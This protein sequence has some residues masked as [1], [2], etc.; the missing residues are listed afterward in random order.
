MT[1]FIL[2]DPIT[3]LTPRVNIHSSVLSFPRRT[4][5]YLMARGIA[6]HTNYQLFASFVSR[7]WSFVLQLIIEKNP[8]TKTTTNKQKTTHTHTHTQTNKQQQQNNQENTLKQDLRIFI[9][10]FV[11]LFVVVF[12]LIYLFVCLFYLFLIYLIICLFLFPIYLF[13]SHAHA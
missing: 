11:C 2:Q 3:R 10:L 5:S 6:L 4:A 8:K 13:T 7:N 9:Y 1:A 12:F